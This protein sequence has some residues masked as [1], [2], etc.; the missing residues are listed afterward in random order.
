MRRPI[1]ALTLAALLAP[2]AAKAADGV[3]EFEARPTAIYA[4]L[5]VGTPLGFIGVEAE[6]TVMP[7]WAVS[8]GAGLGLAGPQAAVMTRKLLGG[9]RSKFVIGAG[10]SGGQYR[11]ED[12]CIDSDGCTQKTGLVAW[13]NLEIGGAHRFGNG[14][15]LRYFGGYGRLI[16]GDLAC[17]QATSAHCMTYHQNDGYNLVYTGVAIGYAF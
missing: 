14:F 6:Q 10:L 3:T 1:L 8:A 12:L 15:A 13:G 11:W 4:Q 17:E 2:A 16:A 5:G 7:T 9:D